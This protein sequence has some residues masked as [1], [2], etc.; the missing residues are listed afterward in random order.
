MVIGTIRKCKNCGREYGL[1]CVIT[2]PLEFKYCND[3]IRNRETST[4]YIPPGYID[5]S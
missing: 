1:G 4:T 5:D 3:C 2:N